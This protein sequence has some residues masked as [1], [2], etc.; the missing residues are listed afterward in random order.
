MTSDS[1]D[2]NMIM[3][4]IILFILFVKNKKSICS[5]YFPEKIIGVKQSC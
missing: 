4:T 5:E 2:Q 1:V 3:I